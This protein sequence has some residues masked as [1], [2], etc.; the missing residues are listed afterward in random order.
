MNF[1]I[2][3]QFLFLIRMQCLR[4]RPCDSNRRVTYLK[5]TAVGKSGPDLKV[6]VRGVASAVKI[7]EEVQH[8]RRRTIDHKG[9]LP[10]CLSASGKR[11]EWMFIFISERLDV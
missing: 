11:K 2:F 8:F 6:G 5:N 9:D 3:V 1:E 4:I 7:P 10:V